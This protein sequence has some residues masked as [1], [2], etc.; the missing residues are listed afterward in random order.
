[1]LARSE[2]GQYRFEDGQ[3]QEAAN[4]LSEAVRLGS[5]SPDVYYMLGTSY[6]KL[7]Q[8]DLAE[9]SLRRA[10]AINPTIGKAYLQ[11]Y[12]VYMRGK[13]PDKAL[14]VVDTYLA[15]YPAASDRAY[16]QSMADKLR[17]ALKPQ[18]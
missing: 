8:L 3:F 2:L 15:K 12:N 17:K 6:Y 16:V 13:A 11:L 10:L 9:A 18:P 4:L 1:M 5:L 7:G 14:K